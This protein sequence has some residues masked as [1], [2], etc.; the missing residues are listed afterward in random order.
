MERSPP[1]LGKKLK[2]EPAQA[3]IHHPKSLGD[4]GLD[5]TLCERVNAMPKTESCEEEVLEAIEE[6]QPVRQPPRRS[7]P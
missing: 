3:P 6:R 2:V 5:R 1:A 4:T 7:A